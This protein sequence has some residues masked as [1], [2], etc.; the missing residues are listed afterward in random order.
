VSRISVVKI[1]SVPDC[2]FS[3][4]RVLLKLDRPLTV[5]LNVL[6]SELVSTSAVSGCRPVRPSAVSVP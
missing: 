1:V 3:R 6:A 2:F 4:S 5:V